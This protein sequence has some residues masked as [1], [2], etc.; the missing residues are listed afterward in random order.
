MNTFVK[1]GDSYQLRRANKGTRQASKYVYIKI[2][3]A[4][5]PSWY[6][7]CVK[8]KQMVDNTLI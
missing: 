7:T 8:S 5:Q 6:Q 1:T 3:F 4:E 2:V